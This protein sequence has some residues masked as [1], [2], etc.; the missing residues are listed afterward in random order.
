MKKLTEIIRHAYG[1]NDEKHKEYLDVKSDNVTADMDDNSE[2]EKEAESDTKK[3]EAELTE[4]LTIY[5]S[6]LLFKEI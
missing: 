3:L 5:I 1:E 2:E 4:L 6:K